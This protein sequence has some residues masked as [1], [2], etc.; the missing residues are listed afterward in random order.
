MKS[1]TK[2]LHRANPSFRKDGD[3][4]PSNLRRMHFYLFGC[5][6]SVTFLGDFVRDISRGSHDST[7]VLRDKA[8]F[9][10]D[11]EDR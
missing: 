5:G 6:N 3:V 8:I 10:D 11:E 9:T 1:D 2:C 4:Y 7:G